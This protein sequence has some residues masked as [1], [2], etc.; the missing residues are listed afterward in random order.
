MTETEMRYAVA[1]LNV[2]SHIDAL[3]LPLSQP[4]AR[5]RALVVEMARL[6]GGE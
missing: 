5:I 4:M 3:P 6:K 2:L 1:V